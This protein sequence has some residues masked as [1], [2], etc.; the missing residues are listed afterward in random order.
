MGL[1]DNLF[2]KSRPDPKVAS[3]W[4]SISGYQP[5]FTSRSG[6]I[7]EA[8]IVRSAI[9]SFAQHASKL[10]P[11]VVGDEDSAL[12]HALES[13]P[14]PWQTTKKFLYRIA[15][16][17][18]GTTTVFIVPITANPGSGSEKVIGLYP[19]MTSRAEIV[20][21]VGSDEPWLR[22]TFADGTKAAIEF[23]RVGILTT[24]QFR[25]E[26]FGDGHRALDSTLDVLDIQEQALVL[27]MKNGA[28]IRFMARLSGTLKDGDIEKERERFTRDN[29]SLKN[30]SGVMLVDSKYEDIKPIEPKPYLMSA[31]QAAQIH[32]RVFNY[33]GTHA[34]ILQNKYD[35]DEWNAYYEGKI[36]PF[37]LDLS[38]ALTNMVFSAADRAKGKKILLAGSR[39]QYAS[40]KTKIAFAQMMTDRGQMNGDEA[41][42][43]FGMP[44]MPDGLG[45]DYYIRGEYINV[46]DIDSYKLERE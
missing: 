23:R 38:Q 40:M 34:G 20:E 31:Q 8:D 33:F 16:I 11:T 28:A 6:S 4:R 30:D 44:P 27:G 17:L 3:F 45:Q 13:Q 37:A 22:Y 24:M 12:A 35:E 21:V 36:E 39:L 46:A 15:T 41:R 1:L 7:Y 5:S 19:L 43:V 2:G 32:E 26:F 14:N 25:D 10:K 42:E 18:D 9:H 29:L